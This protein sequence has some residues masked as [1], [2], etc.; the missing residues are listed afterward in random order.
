V[1]A[2]GNGTPMIAS[3]QRD[4]FH[5]HGLEA[6]QIAVADQVV[7]VLVVTFVADVNAHVVQQRR[8]LEPLALAIGEGVRAA[9]RVEQRKGQPRNL[10]R[11]LRG[12][13][14]SLGQFDDAAT[15]DIG[16]ALSVRD[17]L[18]VSGDV[19]EDDAFTERHVGQRDF[20]S[21]EPSQDD[22]NQH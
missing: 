14:A 3:D 6:A 11:V 19:V 10:V 5:I 16:I 2:D 12:A 22:V 7:R 20:V 9:R 17:L 8:I 1:F 21:P 15:P 18:V 4:R 13:V